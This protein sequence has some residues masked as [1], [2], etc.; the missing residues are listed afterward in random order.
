MEWQVIV[1]LAVIIPVILFPVLVVWYV[2]FRRVLIRTMAIAKVRQLA[3][4]R[5]TVNS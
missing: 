5:V 1:A 3:L 2:N 4:R